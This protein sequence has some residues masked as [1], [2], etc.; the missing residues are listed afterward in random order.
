MAG[1]AAVHFVP[2]RVAQIMQ[3]IFSRLVLKMD[4]A[5]G[6]HWVT[7]RLR[8]SYRASCE[9]SMGAVRVRARETAFS[10]SKPA[11]MLRPQHWYSMKTFAMKN[12]CLCITPR[13]LMQKRLPVNP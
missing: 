13:C 5:L 12:V 4:A 9:A 10:V 8:R 7:L 6:F 3:H 11:A 2:L 1:G